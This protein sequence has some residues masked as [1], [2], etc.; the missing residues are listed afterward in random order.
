MSNRVN[1]IPG[2]DDIAR[3]ELPNGLVVL[4]RENF[5]A[6]SVVVT[7]LLRTGA[8]FD[9]PQT[10]GLADFGTEALLYGTANRS[11]EDIHETLE[12]LGADLEISAGVSSTGF[13]GK[14]LAEDLG[15]LL[16]VLQDALRY[17]AF[18]ADHV[19][20]LRGE[21][22]TSLQMQQHDTRYRAGEAFR[23]L[24][25][26]TDHPY[27]YTPDGTLE[28]IPALGRDLLVDYHR[29]TFGP[30]DAIVA[31]VGAVPA[32]AALDAVEAAL[33]GWTNPDQPPRP[34]IPPAPP[35]AEVHQ[36]SVAVPGKTQSDLVL[37][38][39]APAAATRSSTRRGWSTTCW[40]SLG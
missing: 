37:G 15:V 31:V 16:D 10:L 11:F 12:G 39:P 25:Y 7:G 9:T 4:A 14:A 36:T 28:T 26:P 20:R 29:R 13:G 3:R 5:N 8:I 30:R 19:E 1:P 21:Y 32:E 6:Q 34:T 22:I 27:H 38:V 23:A 2:P 24:A 17:P 40:A 33:G 35:R 18:P